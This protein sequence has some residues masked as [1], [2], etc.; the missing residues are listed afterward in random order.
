VTYSGPPA[1]SWPGVLSQGAPAV[2]PALAVLAL[3]GWYAAAARGVRRRGGHWP[4]RRV[5]AL[6]AGSCVALLAVA[7]PVGAYAPVLFWV[8]SVQLVVLLL[9]AP[10]L[11]AYGRPLA[12]LRLTSAR[13]RLSAVLAAPAVRAVTGPLAGPLV[14][15]A[16]LAASYFTALFPARLH[17]PAVRGVEQL[18]VLALGFLLAVGLVGE[19]DSDEPSGALAAAAAVGFVELLVDAVP[20]IA[21]RL[22]THLLAPAAAAMLHRPWGLP[23]L[24]DQQRGGAVLWGLAEFADL[25][26]LA[27]I[28]RRWL[29]A[30]AREAARVDAEL[31]SSPD[32]PAGPVAAEDR[33]APWWETDPDRLGAAR[34]AR[35]RRDRDR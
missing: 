29:R 13:S 16:V 21:V 19:G 28:L 32:P 20:G 9:V 18:A 11:L 26:F 31:D 14:V 4:V 2:V 35:Y 6:A 3:L 33:A 25:P 8:D 23:P 24:S 5:V 1:P 22:R 10:V 15:P 17:S 30:D 27:V 12:L 7:G 34:A